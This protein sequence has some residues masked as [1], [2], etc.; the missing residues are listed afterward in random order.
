MKKQVKE[1]FRDRIRDAVF[2]LASCWDALREAE[3]LAGVDIETA[4]IEALAGDCGDAGDA[5]DLSS[6]TIFA[7]LAEVLK[8]AR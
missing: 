2:H 6:E 7:A 4:D 8:G 1:E 3:V 5:F